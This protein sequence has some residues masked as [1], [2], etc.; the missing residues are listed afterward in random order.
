MLI[1]YDAISF[2]FKVLGAVLLIC[3]LQIV[4][5]LSFVQRFNFFFV[6]GLHYDYHTIPINRA[7]TFLRRFENEFS[8]SN[9]NFPRVSND[10]YN[11]VSWFKSATSTVVGGASGL[12]GGGEELITGQKAEVFTGALQASALEKRRK[13]L[14]AFLRKARC[15]RAWTDKAGREMDLAGSTTTTNLNLSN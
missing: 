2:V 1:S 6:A 5:R 3:Q 10:P 12:L 8:D 14:F 13:S 7:V 9:S 15:Q 4:Y 11:P